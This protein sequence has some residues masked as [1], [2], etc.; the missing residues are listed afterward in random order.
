MNLNILCMIVDIY[1]MLLLQKKKGQGINTVILIP[2]CNSL[3]FVTLLFFLSILLN[4]LRNLV[5]FC[6]NVDTDKVLLLWKF[7]N[8]L[9]R[10]AI[11]ID[12]YLVGVSNKQCLFTFF[13]MNCPNVCRQIFNQVIF[14]ADISFTLRICFFFFTNT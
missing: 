6:M 11:Y 4:N 8:I 14:L 12:H 13:I 9:N 3:M 7:F 10:A 5:I 1:E 2:L